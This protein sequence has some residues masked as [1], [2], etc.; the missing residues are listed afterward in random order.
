MH[1]GRGARES[2]WVQVGDGS[3]GETGVVSRV[4][5]EEEKGGRMVI[6]IMM[7]ITTLLFEGEGQGVKRWWINGKVIARTLSFM[8]TL[9]QAVPTSD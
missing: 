4:E 9:D 2:V 6:I 1:G 3:E 7:I 8:S 5:E